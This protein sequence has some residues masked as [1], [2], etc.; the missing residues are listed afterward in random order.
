MQKKKQK[1]K[2]LLSAIVVDFF[3][4]KKF[5]RCPINKNV[6][7]RQRQNLQVYNNLQSQ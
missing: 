6:V 3:Q 2:T 7:Y 1:K 5:Q 4:K